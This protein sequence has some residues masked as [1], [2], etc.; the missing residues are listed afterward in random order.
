MKYSDFSFEAFVE[1]FFVKKIITKSYY[2]TKI[3]FI[4]KK[5]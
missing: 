3:Y 1:N 4:K 5:L 2:T